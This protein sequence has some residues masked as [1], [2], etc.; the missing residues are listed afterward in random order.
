MTFVFFF[1]YKQKTAYEMRI[2]DWS[3][4]VCS[5]D[6]LARTALPVDR[7]A[8]DALGETSGEKRRAGDVECLVADL[9]DASGDH[10][11]DD[12]RVEVVALDEGVQGLGEQAAGMHPGGCSARRSEGRRVGKGGVSTW[13]SRGA[14]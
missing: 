3:S 2:S 10:V 14:P 11:V 1:F 13:R 6:L 9:A 7:G 8:G 4:D 5:S 12:G